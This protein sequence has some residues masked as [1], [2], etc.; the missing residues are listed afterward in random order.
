M[1]MSCEFPYLNEKYIGQL[2]NHMN[3]QQLPSSLSLRLK[4]LKKLVIIFLKFMIKSQEK[5]ANHHNLLSLFIFLSLLISKTM[6]YKN[7]KGKLS[8]KNE[9]RS[10]YSYGEF[11]YW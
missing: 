10:W 9:R 11:A 8:L 7:H 4:S 2:R 6:T 5:S 1:N 3:I